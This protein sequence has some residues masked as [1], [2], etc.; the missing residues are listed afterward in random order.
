MRPLASAATC[1][2]LGNRRHAR[3]NHPD[4]IL[5]SKSAQ[6]VRMGMIFWKL[7]KCF[8]VSSG[9]LNNTCLNVGLAELAVLD[10]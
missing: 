9:H 10:G 6:Q 2:G 7:D 3:T 1:P 5:V 4:S 8:M